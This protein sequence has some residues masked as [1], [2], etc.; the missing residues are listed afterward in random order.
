MKLY[1]MQMIADSLGISYDTARYHVLVTGRFKPDCKSNKRCFWT[2]E[3]LN[4]LKA[5]Y[6]SKLQA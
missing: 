3:S 4:R 6:K 5:T 1:S 2:E